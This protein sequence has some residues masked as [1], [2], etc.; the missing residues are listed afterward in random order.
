RWEVATGRPL[1]VAP[2]PDKSRLVALSPAG[3]RHV[4]VGPDG[5]PRLYA[6]GDR[7]LVALPAP[8]SEWRSARFSDDGQTLVTGWN[9]GVRLWDAA[10]G[11]PLGPPLPFPNPRDAAIVYGRRVLAW[12]ETE[13]RLWRVPRPTAQR[14]DDWRAWLTAR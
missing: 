4:V 14:G 5:A 12:H 2:L 8:G 9:D 1:D 3:D 7:G 11:L 13:A 6:S 10:T